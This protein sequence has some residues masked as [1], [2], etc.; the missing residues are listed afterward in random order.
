M[1]TGKSF[2]LIAP[3]VAWMVLMSTLPATAWAYAV[4]GAVTLVLLMAGFLSV[5]DFRAAVRRQAGQFRVWTFGAAAGL[6]V[7]AVWWAPELCPRL[8]AAATGDPSPYDPAVCGWALTIAK[9]LASAFV[10]SV[11]EELFFRLWMVRFAGFGW[12]V[13]LFALNHWRWDLGW[14]GRL[15]FVAEGAFA[16][17]VYGLLARRYGILCSSVAHAVTNLALGL[18][19]VL[20]GQW[21]FW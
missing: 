7:L 18:I 3:Y 4:R 16:G 13:L 1:K 10:I 5:P 9:L 14:D 15:V 8:F 2:W 20:L 19:V 21:H 17:V 11:A 12:M 6:L